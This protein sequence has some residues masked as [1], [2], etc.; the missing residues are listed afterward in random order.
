MQSCNSIIN[1]TYNSQNF[2]DF[3]ESVASF[4]FEGS[5]RGPTNL[6]VSFDEIFNEIKDETYKFKNLIEE[7]KKQLVF[8]NIHTLMQS[9]TS[10]ENYLIKLKEVLDNVVKEYENKKMSKS[11][12]D[13]NDLQTKMLSLLQIDDV[14]KEIQQSYRYIFVDEF[15]D[16]N[17]I[18]YSILEL[19]SNGKNLNMIGDVKQSIY[20]FR[21]ASPDIFINKFNEFNENKMAGEV[22]QFNKNYRSSKNILDFV[23]SIF[24]EI[25]TV[26]TVGINYKET[27]ELVAG[28]ESLKEY[29]SELSKKDVKNI[30]LTVVNT[31][32]LSEEE[33]EDASDDFN[34]SSNKANEER[35]ELTAEEVEANVVVNEINSLLGKPFFNAKTGR[36]EFIAYKDIAI[37]TRSGGKFIAEL[38][39]VL[40]KFKIPSVLSVKNKMRGN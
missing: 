23:N 9:F 16:V 31:T 32:K 39:K 13:F 18:Q 12:L 25:I 5:R 33:N 28:N 15:Q 40:N 22:I 24:N 3:F 38:Q 27:S 19:I 34:S 14:R 10:S 37:L 6:D 35:E 1:K 8:K 4:N 20:E 11:Q 17:E 29:D 21:L 2:E 7:V 26:N 36:E 30:K